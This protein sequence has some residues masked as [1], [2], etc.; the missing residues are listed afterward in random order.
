MRKDSMISE[1]YGE[2]QASDADPQYLDT[3][4]A[5]KKRSAKS[6]RTKKGQ[7]SIWADTSVNLDKSVKSKDIHRKDSFQDSMQGSENED[8]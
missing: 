3:K 2:E 6:R 5:S 7:D 8:Y 1:S 4:H